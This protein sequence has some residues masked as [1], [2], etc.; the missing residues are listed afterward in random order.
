MTLWGTC[1]S[2]FVKLGK[3]QVDEANTDRDSVLVLSSPE[4][5]ACL[6]VFN[7]LGVVNG[8]NAVVLLSPF[9]Q[10]TERPWDAEG[11]GT[12]RKS[13]V[14]AGQRPGANGSFCACS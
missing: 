1:H 6:N 4:V 13:P 9:K 2:L 3:S 5:T 12:E 10:K 8:L 14:K 7:Q 11:F